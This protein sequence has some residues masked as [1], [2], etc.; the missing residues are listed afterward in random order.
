MR[1]C[2]D[3]VVVVGKTEKRGYTLSVSPTFD[4]QL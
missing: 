2:V 3:T 4:K 1:C